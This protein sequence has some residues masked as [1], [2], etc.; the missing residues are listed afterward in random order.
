MP[1]IVD[2]IN[3][4][5]SLEE[6]PDKLRAEIG[7]YFSP[8][9]RGP[10]GTSFAYFRTG[11]K[12]D[13]IHEDTSHNQQAIPTTKA[14]IF[15]SGRDE[16]FRDQAQWQE[17]IQDTIK[18]GVNNLDHQ[19]SLQDIEIN[20]TFV[21]NF[22]DP[23]YE[24]F[25]KTYASNQLL[26]YN[27][28]NYKHK[29]EVGRVG[30]I[31]DLVSNF[32]DEN[33]Q[34][35]SESELGDLFDQFANR[36]ANYSGSIE[37]VDLKQRNI[38]KLTDSHLFGGLGKF[39]FYYQKNLPTVY[40]NTL[41]NLMS[42]HNKDKNI[43]QSIKQNLSFANRQF[44]IGTTQITG[45]IH[46]LIDIVFS[47][48]INFIQ[49][50]TNE[51]FLPREDEIDFGLPNRRFVEQFNAVRFLSD[52]RDLINQESRSIERI[53]DSQPCKSYFVAYK[54]E[55]YL[56]RDNT[57]PIQTYYIN[58][59]KLLFDTQLKYGREYIYKT[60][61]LVAVLG[62][63]YKY[64]NLFMSQNETEM[65]N[66]EGVL[67][68]MSP[69]GF[70]DI[71][72]EK[73]RA[74]VDVE[75]TPSFQV[76]E[77][78]IDY[79]NVVFI[80]TPASKPQVDFYN[81]SKKGTIEF[82][83]SPTIFIN[84]FYNYAGQ[85]DGLQGD[86]YDIISDSDR[87]I[88]YLLQVSN[89]SYNPVNYFTGIYEIYRVTD[90]PTSHSDFVDDLIATVDDKSTLSFPTGMSLPTEALDNMNGHFEDSIMV[91]RKYYYL[92]RNLTY[93]GTPSRVTGPFEIELMKDSDEYKISVTKYNY[94]ESG[95]Y[96]KS[97]VAKRIMQLT[98]NIDRL[99]F[100]ELEKDSSGNVIYKLDEDNMLTTSQP[101]KIK[102]RVTSKHTGKKMDIN[103]NLVLKEDTNSFTQN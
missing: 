93:H 72:N 98:P 52:F 40:A 29:G 48:R 8:E 50:S 67:S 6:A 12:T 101:R 100:S 11:I 69:S 54:V 61:A 47:D 53:F 84:K 15:V 25:T 35:T 88:E 2:S 96:P 99:Q 49:E 95:D 39:P 76:L 31:A 58:N 36:I 37:E 97:T 44:N 85:T 89:D 18:T 43:L 66:E 16:Q 59:S 22:H 5:N 79:D 86:E 38:F 55:K 4:V 14:K 13:F 103:I 70:S 10:F 92:F 27:L 19:F 42:R 17:F 20:N 80:D 28:I 41:H 83:F 23:T 26:N 91:N 63:S 9:N 94:P 82:F 34:V 87:D 24:D 30:N 65:I 21:K 7:R 60:K 33:Y 90:P 77:Y 46:N 62:S 51:L 1:T 102:L 74:Y 73:Y 32:D 3:V 64:S 71:S 81:N 78:E 45:K 57:T 68:N 56:D 75:V